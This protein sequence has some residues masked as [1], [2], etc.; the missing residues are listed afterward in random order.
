MAASISAADGADCN[1]GDFCSSELDF[2]SEKK[3]K[4]K[5][6]K[7]NYMFWKDKKNQKHIPNYSILKK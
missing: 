3:K 7:I 6:K 1:S 5:K 4:K 2:D